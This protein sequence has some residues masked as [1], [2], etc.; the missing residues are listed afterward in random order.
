MP[1]HISKYQEKYPEPKKR[2]AVC[3]KG[4]SLAD[5]SPD[6][7][8]QTASVNEAILHTKQGIFTCYDLVKEFR[9]CHEDD[10]HESVIPIIPPRVCKNY[11]N[12]E[13]YYYQWPDISLKG[14][15]CTGVQSICIACSLGAE[16][17]VLYGFDA[18]ES[19]DTSYHE[20]VMNEQNKKNLL[21]CQVP[22][23]CC[24]PEEWQRKCRFF[25]SGAL[26]SEVLRR[27]VAE[28]GANLSM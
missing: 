6:H 7:V 16:E 17:I 25:G 12:R 10:I 24:V 11:M 28:K 9:F 3:G 23:F 19:G 22:Q 15:N 5:W 18:L 27:R 14:G 4:K 20:P 21:R 8:D 13:A 2:W 1:E 26:L